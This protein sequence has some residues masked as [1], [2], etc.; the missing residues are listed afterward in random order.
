MMESLRRIEDKLEAKK[1][2]EK[3]MMG[4]LRQSPVRCKS[5]TR[6]E[7]YNRIVKVVVDGLDR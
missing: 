6:A 4:R 7:N 5:P 2:E 3:K 1:N